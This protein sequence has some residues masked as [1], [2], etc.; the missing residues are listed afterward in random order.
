MNVF[1]QIKH[2]NEDC[3]SFSERFALWY[4]AFV[5]VGIVIPILFVTGFLLG[6]IMFKNPVATGQELVK[7]LF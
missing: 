1:T 2:A 3:E 5:G 7:S 4:R 6:C